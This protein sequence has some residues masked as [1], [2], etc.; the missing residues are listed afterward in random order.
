[1]SHQ[2]WIFSDTFTSSVKAKW[3]KFCLLLPA[4]G[5]LTTYP[6]SD[7]T[8]KGSLCVPILGILA[9]K[10]LEQGWCQLP[11]SWSFCWVE[12]SSGWIFA[13]ACC[14]CS[15]C[16][17]RILTGVQTLRWNAPLYA[18]P[19]FLEEPFLSSG[20]LFAVCQLCWATHRG[21]GI[22]SSLANF[23]QWMKSL[24]HYRGKHMCSACCHRS[25]LRQELSGD[26]L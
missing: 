25:V 6:S 16:F 9:Q 7:R 13:S 12:H 26:S 24:I 2:V 22:V 14:S 8:A 21:L 20:L 1:M 3:Q 15:L 11:S 4:M 10:H 18:V 23:D 5:P 19:L 17:P